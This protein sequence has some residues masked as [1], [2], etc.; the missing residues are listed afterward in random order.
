[1]YALYCNGAVGTKSYISANYNAAFSGFM[2]TC[3]KV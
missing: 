3:K 1:M 2:C